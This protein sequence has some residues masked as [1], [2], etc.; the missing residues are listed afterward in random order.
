MIAIDRSQCASI[1]RPTGDA[2]SSC[3]DSKKLAGILVE[4]LREFLSF[5]H[6]D[7]LIVKQ[8]PMLSSANAVEISDINERTKLTLRQAVS[9]CNN[10]TSGEK[11]AEWSFSVGAA[12]SR[13][14][15]CED[16]RFDTA[17]LVDLFQGRPAEAVDFSAPRDHQTATP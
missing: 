5:D 12:S 16:A 9:K 6:L 15:S 7:V 2:L 1:E 13:T 11:I 14:R 10:L 3:G 4:Q 8:N 17:A